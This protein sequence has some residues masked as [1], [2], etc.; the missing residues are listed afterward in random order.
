M[1]FLGVREMR[2]SYEVLQE[3]LEREG[4]VIL[5]RHGKP[6]ARVLPYNE[7]PRKMPSLKEFRARQKRQRV[8]TSVAIRAERDER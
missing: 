2:A 3:T 1:K 8:P 4:E 5:T 6:F 7:H